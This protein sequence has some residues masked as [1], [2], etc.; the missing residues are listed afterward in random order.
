MLKI[1]KR[2]K[3]AESKTTALQDELNA[4]QKLKEQPTV[5]K[6]L[7]YR[8]LNKVYVTRETPEPEFFSPQ[9][10]SELEKVKQPEF[11]GDKAIVN[12]IS[13][14]CGSNSV[15]SVFEELNRSINHVIVRERREI[16]KEDIEEHKNKKQALNGQNINKDKR[17]FDKHSSSEDEFYDTYDSMVAASESEDEQEKVTVVP[18]DPNRSITDE[19]VLSDSDSDF[20]SG[21]IAVAT[22]KDKRNSSSK[23][24]NLESDDFF[25]STNNSMSNLPTLATGYVSGSDDEDSYDYDNDKVVKQVVTERKNR[26]G[27]RARRKIWELKYGKKANHVIKEREEH[28]AGA[29]KR[30]QEYE[31]RE[32][33]RQ[34]K[35]IKSADAGNSSGMGSA[36][37]SRGLPVRVQSTDKPLHPSWQAKKNLKV[38]AS[39]FEGKKLKFDD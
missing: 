13:R 37:T 21:N 10:L 27:Q 6:Y 15:K 5:A 30:Q 1:K 28:A 4:A 39:A 36:V 31:E 19:G 3:K 25:A 20:E 8:H 18:N 29:R 9:T 23:G 26:R 12:V 32:L 17:E 33:K 35:R 11:A 34:A 38:S 22:T 14:L 24:S 7:V 16:D 2:M